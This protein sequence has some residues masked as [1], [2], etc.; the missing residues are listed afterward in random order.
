MEIILDLPF[1]FPINNIISLHVIV[2]IMSMKN[3]SPRTLSQLVP[4]IHFKVALAHTLVRQC[5]VYIRPWFGTLYTRLIPH[6]QIL[7]LCIICV[8]WCQALCAWGLSGRKI[9]CQTTS[10]VLPLPP[11]SFP[12]PFVQRLFVAGCACTFCSRLPCSCIH[13]AAQCFGAVVLPA[14]PRRNLWMHLMSCP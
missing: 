7:S 13:D 10:F 4:S 5:A 12:L 8:R 3:G 11:S 6:S 14:A 1:G 2:Y 9:Q